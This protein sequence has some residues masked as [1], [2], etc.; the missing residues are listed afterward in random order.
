MSSY[1]FF[2]STEK[3]SVYRSGD[4]GWLEKRKTMN[5]KM[6]RNHFCSKSII[7]LVLR[8]TTDLTI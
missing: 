3:V 6:F 2:F 5:E 1:I 4:Q 8:F 7:F